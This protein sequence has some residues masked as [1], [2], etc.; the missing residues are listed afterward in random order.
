MKIK[1]LVVLNDSMEGKMFPRDFYGSKRV[2]A[3]CTY[4]N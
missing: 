2:I 1:E 4:E 3:S